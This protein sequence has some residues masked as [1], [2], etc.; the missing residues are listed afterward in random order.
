MSRSLPTR[1]ATH[2]SNDR[3]TRPHRPHRRRR[4]PGGEAGLTLVETIIS[5]AVLALALSGVAQLL[6]VGSRMNHFAHRMGTASAVA[7]DLLENMSLWAYDDPRLEAKETLLTQDGEQAVGDFEFGRQEEVSGSA[8]PHYGERDDGIAETAAA[9]AT[10]DSPYRGVSLDGNDSL[11]ELSRYW[12]VYAL[13]PDGDG[14]EEGKIILVGVRWHE[15]G[16]GYRHVTASSF[17]G[18]D[19]VFAQ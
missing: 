6:L 19:R 16:V 15:P 5:F 14:I 1:S 18:N 8:R 11:P 17:L 3:V 10:E 12:N 7:H 9:L 13:D 2:D 4:P